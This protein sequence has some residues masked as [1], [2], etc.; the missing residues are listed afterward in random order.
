MIIWFRFAKVAFF[1][2]IV[3]GKAMFFATYFHFPNESPGFL[4]IKAPPTA[5]KSQPKQPIRM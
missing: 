1:K 5:S 3:A 2:I 4:P